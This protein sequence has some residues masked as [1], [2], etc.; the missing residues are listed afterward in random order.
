MSDTRICG[1]CA[2]PI[3]A[4]DPEGLC[5]RCLLHSALSPEAESSRLAGVR[6][7]GTL[8][9]GEYEL[10]AEIGSGGQGVVYRAKHK[11]LNRVVAL[12]CIPEG[13]FS[14]AERVARF[15]TE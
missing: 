4:H 3:R 2:T 11:R 7:A 12:K 14:S 8:E 10:L 15:R 5:L 1:Q 9:F 6:R 13:R